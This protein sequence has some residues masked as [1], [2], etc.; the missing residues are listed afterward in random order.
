MKEKE[1]FC[2]VILDSNPSNDVSKEIYNFEARFKPSYFLANHSNE[3]LAQP[4]LGL[5]AKQVVREDASYFLKRYS[6]KPW[7]KDYIGLVSEG[8]K[9][10]AK[11]V[12]AFANA[13]QLFQKK[14]AG[15]KKRFY[16]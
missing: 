1:D 12:Q 14:V 4:Y 9:E 15:L 8:V 10:L 3:P 7:A 6:D 5:A 13:A 2:K 11:K 16:L